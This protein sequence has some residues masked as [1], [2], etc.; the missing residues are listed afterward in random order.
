[1]AVNG[2]PERELSD[3]RSE[4]VVA[5][6]GDE[7]LPV[8]QSLLSPNSMASASSSSSKLLVR[9]TAGPRP[10]R[11]SRLTQSCSAKTI[12]MTAEAAMT[13]QKKKESGREPE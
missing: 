6:P 11:I 5:N 4:V 2:A 12:M 9:A 3:L 1:M 13:S 7:A 8:A 10:S